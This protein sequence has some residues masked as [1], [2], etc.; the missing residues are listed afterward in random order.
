LQRLRAEALL[1]LGRGDEADKVAADWSK[2][3]ASVP[4]TT[5]NLSALLARYGRNEMAHQLL[6]Q[7]LID[8]SLK[9]ELRLALLRQQADTRVGLARWRLLLQAVEQVS[10]NVR[11]GSREDEVL[12]AA[13]PIQ[14]LL[15]ELVDPGQ[16]EIAGQLAEEAG[17]GVVRARLHLRQAELVVDPEQSAAICWQLIQ[18]GQMPESRLAWAV[19]K[20]QEANRPDWVIELLENRLRAGQTLDDTLRFELETAYRSSN[21]PVD[22][23]RARTQDTLSVRSVPRPRRGMG[24]GF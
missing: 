12:M 1:R 13:E 3:Q 9:P 4:Q 24:G 8:K 17:P 15:A 2:N 19:H 16:Q 23:L 21:R 7:A 5:A 10:K 22:A 6:T 20:M 18:E 11:G 14:R